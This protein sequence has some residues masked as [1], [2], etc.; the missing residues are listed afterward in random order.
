MPGPLLLR[1]YR[2]ARDLPAI[3]SVRA[4]VQEADG[5][6]RMPGPDTVDDPD[7]HLPHCAIAEWDGDVAGYTWLTWWTEADGT[8]LYLLLGWV[9]PRWRG[10]GI[11]RAMLAWQEDRAAALAATHESTGPALF[12]A[13]AG[14]HQADARALLLRAGYRLAFTGVQ[15]AL[16]LTAGPPPPAPTMP[17]GLVVRPARDEHKE[18]IYQVNEEIFRDSHRGLGHLTHTFA[19]YEEETADT[20]LWHVAWDG[21]E[22]AGWVLTTIADDGTGI[23]PWV[24]VRPAWRGRGL[25]RALV[26]L[27]LRDFVERGVTTARINTTAENPF[28]TVALYESAGYQVVKRHPRYL[29]PIAT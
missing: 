29:K 22:P 27:S 6:L 18:R 1:P 2:D 26:A 13:N 14:E 17:P 23:T 3:H 24:A 16:D 5:D 28:G 10:H 11:G 20:S 8:R 21:D 4:A 12:G 9:V 19:D 7:R 25:A 15:L